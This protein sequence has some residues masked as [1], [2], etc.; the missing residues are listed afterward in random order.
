MRL[1]AIIAE[2]LGEAR[3]A[4]GLTLQDL[5]VAAGIEEETAK[6]RMHQYE[7]GKHLPPYSML[8]RLAETLGKP[9]SWFVCEEEQKNLILALEGLSKTELSVVEVYAQQLLEN[10][11]T[12][13][14]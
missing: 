6:V 13:T 7:Q 3:K 10:R 5:G 9:I 12:E 2:R 8:E 14:R 4:A 1:E 11:T